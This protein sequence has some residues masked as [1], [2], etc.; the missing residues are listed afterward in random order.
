M[1]ESEQEEKTRGEGQ[2]VSD[3]AA[4]AGADDAPD[5]AGEGVVPMA[6]VAAVAAVAAPRFCRECGAAWQEGWQDCPVC[7]GARG[8][9]EAIDPTNDSG[10]IGNVKKAVGLYFALL[11]VCAV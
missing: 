2:D 11:A 9:A 5:A 7:V 1:D 4:A 3:A 6:Q 8:V 10:D